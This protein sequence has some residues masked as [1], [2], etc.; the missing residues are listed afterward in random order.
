MAQPKRISRESVLEKATGAFVDGNA[1]SMD[2]IAAAA[3]VSRAALYELFG[4]RAAIL[5]ALGVEQ[6]PSW[7]DRIL[8][9]GAE[10]LA[11]RGLNG[12]SLDEVA[13]RSGA[14]RATVYRLFPGRAALFREIVHTYLSVDEAMEMMET[15][16]QRPPAE[17]MPLLA[18]NLAQSGN[19]RIG[20]LRSA[21]FEV[22]A[23]LDGSEEVIEEVL[24]ST[25]VLTRY[26]A[27]QMAAGHLRAMHPLLA[28]QSFVAP[29]IL[30]MVSRPLI[31]DFGLLDLPLDEVVR[32]LTDAWLRAMAPPRRR[33]SPV[34]PE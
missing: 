3:G 27:E 32:E 23:R 17:V 14:S 24:Q 5:E 2:E 26:L 9:T 21:L 29:I 18:I 34:R 15:M 7:Q 31:E 16:G 22:T 4:S 1:P 33:P 6:Q 28:M 19:V 25:L 30:H 11:E 12:L 8:V 20:V 13:T 10:L